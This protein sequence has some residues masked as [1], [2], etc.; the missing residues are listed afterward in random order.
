MKTL[1]TLIKLN[2][3]TLDK[4]LVDINKTES[5]KSSL[6][7]HSQKLEQEVAKEVESYHGSD[8]SFMLEKYL[9]TC[10]KKQTRIKAQIDRLQKH[11][12]KRRLELQEQYAELKKY[13][14][15]LQNKQKQ[16][17]IKAQKEETKILDEFGAKQ[18]FYDGM[19]TSKR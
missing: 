8:Y 10:R 18:Y 5:E 4:I 1:Q 11:I 15:A 6:I 17:Y 19:T 12:E 2:K 13:E 14:I 3:N 16:E 9:D 7:D